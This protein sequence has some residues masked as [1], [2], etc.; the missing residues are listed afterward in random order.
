VTDILNKLNGAHQRPKQRQNGDQRQSQLRAPGAVLLALEARAPWELGAALAA[1]PL[2]RNAP[3]GDKHAV[4]VFP[5]LGAPDL[6][7]LP[8]RNF[9]SSHG[10]EAYGW[11]LGFNFGPRDGV[12]ETCVERFK[13]LRM[14]T[15]RKLSLV[16]WSLGGIYAREIAK[17]FPDEVRCVITLGTP[18]TGEPRA[19]NAWRLYQF[20]SGHKLDDP[21]LLAHVR[22]APPVPTTS[23]LSRSDGVVA[24]Q[25]SYEK[26]SHRAENIEIIASHLGLGL[27]PAAWYAVADRLAQPEGTWKPFHRNGWRQWVYLDPERP[28]IG[29]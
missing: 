17:M 24:W 21:E 22:E 3:R 29:D 26:T 1:W 13:D 27:H 25:C 7:T 12:L 16:G 14:E 10:F 4:L 23:I 6:T 15:G 19:T 9:L 8:L 28:F 2:L 5:G 11:D 20:A 18:F